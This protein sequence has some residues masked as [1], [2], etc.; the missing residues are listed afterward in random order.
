MAVEA[1][2]SEYRVQ[3]Y[4]M[5]EVLNQVYRKLLAFISRFEAQQVSRLSQGNELVCVQ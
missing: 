5:L 2:E 3:Y 1:M 4:A